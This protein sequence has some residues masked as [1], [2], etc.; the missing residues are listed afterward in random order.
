MSTFMD[1][2]T[3]S[4]CVDLK[5]C[6]DVVVSP[7]DNMWAHVDVLNFTKEQNVYSLEELLSEEE[8]AQ[9]AGNNS[10]SSG[11]SGIMEGIKDSNC[12]KPMKYKVED[13]LL[14]EGFS[15]QEDKPVGRGFKGFRIKAENKGNT[16]KICELKSHTIARNSRKRMSSVKKRILKA[17]EN[18]EPTKLL[19]KQPKTE[20][21]EEDNILKPIKNDAPTKLLV[22]PPNTNFASNAKCQ[23]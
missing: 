20:S 13:I 14:K 17:I 19:K 2:L 9:S 21:L 18:D 6:G 22:K 8:Y 1:M 23:V 11:D 5:K 10:S 7:S 15:Q 3:G 12:Q 4:Q 16:L